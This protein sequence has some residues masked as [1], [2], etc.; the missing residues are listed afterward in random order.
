[1]QKVRRD[2]FQ[3]IFSTDSEPAQEVKSPRMINYLARVTVTNVLTD[4]VLLL[5]FENSYW[6]DKMRSYACPVPYTQFTENTVPEDPEPF[7]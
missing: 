3:D 7:M 1:M 2:D 4:E 5:K 6:L